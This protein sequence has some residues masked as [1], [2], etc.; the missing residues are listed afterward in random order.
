MTTTVS[1][2]ALI[3]RP[4]RIAALKTLALRWHRWLALAGAVAVLT[5]AVSGG[6]HLLATIT[7]PAQAVFYPPQQPLD[8]GSSLPIDQILARHDIRRANS[9]QIVAGAAGRLLQVTEDPFEPRRY[10]DL[11]TGNERPWYDREHALFL[12]QHYLGVNLPADEIRFVTEFSDRYPWV[13]RLLPVW[14]IAFDNGDG[15]VAYVHT[16]TNAL[17]SLTD[18]A[19]TRLQLGF[20]WLHT[21]SWMPRLA[22]PLRV[23][24]MALLVGSIFAMALTGLGLLLTIRRKQRARGAR[25]IHRLAAWVLAIPLLMFSG[26]GLFHLV[27]MALAPAQSHLRLADPVSMQEPL[28]D[29][30]GQWQNLTDGLAVNAVSLV[31]AGAG[32]RLLRLGLDTR[33]QAG[34][35]GANAIREARFQGI[36]TTGPAIYLDAATGEAWPQGDREL[37]LRFAE[38]HTGH[39]RS[40]VADITLINRFGNGYDFRNKRLPVWR[41]DYQAPYNESVFIDTHGAVLVDRMAHS[42][43][44]EQWSFTF[45]HKWNFLRPLGREIQNRVLL[46]VVVSVIGLIGGLGLYMEI[47]RRRRRPG[48]LAPTPG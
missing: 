30:S 12:A 33:R 1:N 35:Q 45:L 37:A 24:V 8:L 19:H 28:F 17:A 36:P 34:P 42:R 9:L 23:T 46:A 6:L 25:G 4:A 29:L 13:N 43:W 21:W 48:S 20:Q 3:H 44:I 7:G 26:S 40:R 32:E 10:F 14:R 38:R 2:P 11:E 22:E 31:E 47:K 27:Q 41:I 16:E 39:E 5:W 18:R 15:L